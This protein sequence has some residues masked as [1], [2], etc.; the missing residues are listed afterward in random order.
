MSCNVLLH[1]CTVPHGNRRSARVWLLCCTNVLLPAQHSTDSMNR[2]VRPYC[3]TGLYWSV[4]HCTALYLGAPT[5]Q[6]QLQPKPSPVWQT[7][8]I[9]LL[10]CD[11]VLYYVRYYTVLYLTVMYINV[12]YYCAVLHCRSQYCTVIWTV[13][14]VSYTHLTLPNE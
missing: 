1:S 12:R 6:Q 10:G 11:S 2:T 14:P 8:A 3:T 7:W 5:V 13:L 4:L 9:V